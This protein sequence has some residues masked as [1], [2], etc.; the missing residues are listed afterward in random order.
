MKSFGIILFLFVSSLVN[1]NAQLIPERFKGYPKSHVLPSEQLKEQLKANDFSKLLNSKD[2]SIVYGFIGDN[3][4]RIRVKF[5]SIKQDSLFFD[6]YHVYGKSMVKNNIDEFNGEIKIVKIYKLI[7]T[8]HGCE[9]GYK[10]KG[11]KGQFSLIGEYLFSEN[12]NQ[13][14]SGIFK[15]KV[16]SDYF[17]NKY[18]KVCYNDIE[19]CADGFTNN[20][21]VGNWISY[22][23]SEIKRCN[24]GD[25]R[26]PNSGDLDMG[27]GEFSPYDKYLKYGW[28]SRRDYFLQ[29][30]PNYQQAQH[31]EEAK[32]WL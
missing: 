28:Q 27:A 2:N 24:W 25:Y 17:I 4:Q 18:N 26:V 6:I 20:Q 8:Q 3:Y 7:V 10:Y 5:I 21:F 31:I 23:T 32:W 13:E 1:V 22:Q 29:S 30:G 9:D 19:N 11:Y 16:Q 15:G 12:K 14:H